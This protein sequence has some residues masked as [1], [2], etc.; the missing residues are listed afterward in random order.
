[1]I[2]NKQVL[3]IISWCQKWLKN[4]QV[5]HII[6]DSFMGFKIISPWN[7][8]AEPSKLASV[9]FS[10]CQKISSYENYLIAFL[11]S[12]KISQVQDIKTVDIFV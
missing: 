6:S 7:N 9:I 5:A 10:L 2:Q 1:M 12:F 3:F 11:Y 4:H 8:F